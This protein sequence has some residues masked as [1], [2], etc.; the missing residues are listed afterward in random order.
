M[1]P[2]YREDGITPRRTDIH[3]SRMF[4]PVHLE[5]LGVVGGNLEGVEPTLSIE[6]SGNQSEPLLEE[7]ASEGIPEEQ[8]ERRHM[9]KCR[10]K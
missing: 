8:W 7:K 3:P 1:A 5:P 10:R 4:L 2:R 6:S 9:P